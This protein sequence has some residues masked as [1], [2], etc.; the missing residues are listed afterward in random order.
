MKKTEFIDAVAAKA[1]I[2]KT[3]ASKNVNAVLDVI[4]AALA[5]G[6]DVV[7]TG[8]GTFKVRESKARNGVN[9]RTKAKIKIPATKRPSFSAG[10]VLK[11]SVGE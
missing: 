5:S 8:F 4:S 9:P 2:T 6:D 11:K 7:L 3:E 10:A 1:G